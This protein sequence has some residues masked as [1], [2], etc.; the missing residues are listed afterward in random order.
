[1]KLLLVAATEAEIMPFLQQLRQSWSSPAHHV[2]THDNNEIHICITGVGVVAT[3]FAVTKALAADAFDFALQAGVGGAFDRNI[4]LGSLVQVHAERLGDLGAE[5]HD[6]YLDIFDMG[7]LGADAFPFSGKH[8]VSKAGI[9]FAQALPA[10]T[11]LT[12]STVSGSERTI[13]ARSSMFNCQVESME[14]AAF[15]YV[16]LQE[17]VPFTQVRSISNYVEPRDKSMWKMKDAIIALNKWLI[18]N[19]VQ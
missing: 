8:L 9:P 16:C 4:P 3:T 14:G 17:K 7:L 18:D 13:A 15:H 11:G 2:Y 19:L 6:S 12:I 10:V 5:D 1:M